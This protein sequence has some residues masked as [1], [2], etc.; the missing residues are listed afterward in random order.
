MSNY[1]WSIFKFLTISHQGVHCPLPLSRSVTKRFL[2][3]IQVSNLNLHHNRMYSWVIVREVGLKFWFINILLYIC[4]LKIWKVFQFNISIAGGLNLYTA[5]LYTADKRLS[6]PP[7]P[8]HDL[9]L[10]PSWTLKVNVF[11]VCQEM[12]N[13]WIGGDCPCI[14]LWYAKGAGIQMTGAI[15]YAYKIIHCI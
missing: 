8:P 5:H 11:P 1:H 7:P 15:E 6:A 4:T 12:I 13:Q 10:S 2:V 3:S 14:P 9:T